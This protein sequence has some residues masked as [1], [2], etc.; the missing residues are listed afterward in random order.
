MMKLTNIKLLRRLERNMKKF[1]IKEYK[2]MRKIYRMNL[3]FRRSWR[4]NIKKYLN[5]WI[6]TIMKKYF[7]RPGKKLQMYKI[8]NCTKMQM[9]LIDSRRIIH[10]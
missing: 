3:H 6:Q 7:L 9:I 2:I 5:K 1:G 8:L 10:I 4:K